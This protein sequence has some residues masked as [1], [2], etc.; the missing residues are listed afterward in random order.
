MKINIAQLEECGFTVRHH[1]S[2]GFIEIYPNDRANMS[3]E[4]RKAIR[5]V[6]ALMGLDDSGTD[7]LF[8]AAHKIQVMCAIRKC[9]NW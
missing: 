6:A 4:L 1:H 2:K 3:E 5:E 9:S 7:D 8:G